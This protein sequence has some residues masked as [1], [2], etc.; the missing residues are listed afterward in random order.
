MKSITG[1]RYLTRDEV[2]YLVSL[3]TKPKELAELKEKLTIACEVVVDYIIPKE[4]WNVQ[5]KYPNII[6]LTDHVM[7][8]IGGDFLDI[9]LPNKRIP[10]IKKKGNEHGY[11]ANY[12]VVI[13]D[14]LDKIP[15]TYRELIM[16]WA[17][18]ILE[19]EEEHRKKKSQ[20]KYS[21]NQLRTQEIHLY[22][23][24][25]Y[26]KLMEKFNQEKEKIGPMLK[27]LD[28]KIKETIN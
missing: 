4:L 18:D 2:N 7:F 16:D 15:D 27:D 24:E 25:Y 11:R 5:T 9:T 20:F 13:N 19:M 8:D 12:G 23:P 14:Y 17:E 10:H 22:Y 3:Y 6:K 28:K 26:D 1:N 21:I